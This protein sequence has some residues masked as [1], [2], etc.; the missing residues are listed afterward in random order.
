MTTLRKTHYKDSVKKIPA[1]YAENPPSLRLTGLTIRTT[2]S[3][4]MPLTE[5]WDAV[6]C[7]HCLKLKKW[8]LHPLLATTP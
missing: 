3:R 7:K 5:D 4:P 1:C 6:T 2:Q 8:Y